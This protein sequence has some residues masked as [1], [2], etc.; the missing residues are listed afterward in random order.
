MRCDLDLLCKNLG[1]VRLGKSTYAGELVLEEKPYEMEEIVV[2]DRRIMIDPT[3]TITGGNFT[4]NEIEDLPLQ[5]N[6]QDIAV[7]LTPGTKM[8]FFVGS[9]DQSCR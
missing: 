3:A 6:Y 1:E 9:P 5:R 8:G 7:L 4:K 2:R